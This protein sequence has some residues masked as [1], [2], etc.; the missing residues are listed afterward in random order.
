MKKD[1]III[2]GGASGLFAAIMA[3]DR[4]CKVTILDA[5]EKAGKKI[6]VTGNGRCNLSNTDKLNDKYYCEDIR[7]IDAVFDRFSNCDVQT[8]FNRLGVAIKDK[9]GYLYPNSMQA[10]TVTAALISACQILG[11]KILNTCIVSDIQIQKDGRF[12]IYS[13]ESQTYLADKVLMAFGSRAGLKTDNTAYLLN[14][15]KM[16]GHNIIPPAPALC[17]V[18]VNMLTP[19]YRSFFKNASGVR[20][21]INAELIMDGNFVRDYGGE[22][23]ITEYGLSGIVIFQLSRIVGRAMLQNKQSEI[24]INIDF[25]PEYTTQEVL[26]MLKNQQ[27]YDKKSLLDLCSGLLNQKLA[28]ELIHLFSEQMNPDIKPYMKRL[29]D[30]VLRNIIDFMKHIPFKI[31]KTND[32]AKAQVCS[33]GVDITGINPETLESK[34]VKNLYFSGECIDVDGICGGYNLQWAWSTGYIAGRSLSND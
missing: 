5:N 6:L 7:F 32:F 33:G 27:Y 4:G 29:S 12:K 26:S 28:M 24:Y 30:D 9:N 2:G 11:V 3:A 31:D 20:S 19:S 13:T 17:S 10:S 34:L 18:Y 25:L 22:L 21:E 14:S 1:V 15:L 16:L 8:A 23:Q